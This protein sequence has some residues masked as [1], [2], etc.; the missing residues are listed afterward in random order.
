M[1]SQEIKPNIFYV[2][3][4]DYDRRLFDDLIPLPDGTSYNS[5]LVIGSKKTALIKMYPEAK[6]V[7]NP[8]GKEH[9]MVHLHIPEEKFLVKKDGETLSLGDKTLQFIEAPWVHWPETMF[10]LVIED[11]I[12]FSCDLFGTH[13]A[14][15]ETFVTD[16]AKTYESAKRYYA[17]IMMPFRKLIVKHCKKLEDYD[18]DMIAPSHGPIHKNPKH[19]IDAYKDWISDDVKNEVVLPY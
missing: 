17:E 6:V 12:L 10:T 15:S 4:K 11:K 9:L 3:A 14:Q 7:T 18:F 8:K 19:I 5:Y 13:L 16:E 1:V 2:G